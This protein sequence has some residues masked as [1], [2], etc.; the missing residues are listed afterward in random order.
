MAKSIVTMYPESG[1]MVKEDGN[2]I[3]MA[4]ILEA[5]Y[6]SVNGLLKTSA[7]LTYE[8][9]ITIGSVELKDGATETKATIGLDGLHVDVQAATAVFQGNKTLTGAADQLVASQ[10][11]KT[12]TVQ[13]DPSNV[14]SVKIGTS[15]VDSTH[16]MF[17]LSP[18]SSMTFTV[19][20]VNLLYALGAVSD[21]VSFGGE[22]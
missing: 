21:K 13:A 7:A 3:N 14:G 22:V 19:K 17:I 20:N 9:D 4:D 5:V 18:G 6:D 12:V 15:A 1:R 10:L 16:Y 8:G 11:C 2:T